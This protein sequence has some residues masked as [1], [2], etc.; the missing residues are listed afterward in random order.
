MPDDPFPISTLDLPVEVHPQGFYLMDKN[1]DTGKAR[2]IDKSALRNV[3]TKW[4]G[5]AHF[6]FGG[7]LQS[8][9]ENR[10]SAGN[11]LYSVKLVDPREILSNTEL[12]L[13]NY[14]GTTFNNKNLYNIYGLLEFRVLMIKVL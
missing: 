12:V 14:A 10:S 7:I 1:L 8:Y 11:P 4:R 2:W 3:D 6:A 5:F 13:N 9:T